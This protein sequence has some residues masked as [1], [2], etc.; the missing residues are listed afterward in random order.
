MTGGPAAGH[1]ARGY[2]GMDMMEKEKSSTLDF[3]VVH[4]T[5]IWERG[6]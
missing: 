3:Y 1:L 4:R 2:A 5:E 6:T